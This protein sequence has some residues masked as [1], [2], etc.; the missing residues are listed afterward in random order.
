MGM[1]LTDT[2]CTFL[3]RLKDERAMGSGDD[4]LTDWEQEFIDDQIERYD[5][6][7]E[8]TRLSSRQ[9]EI[10]HKIAEKMGVDE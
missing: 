1:T 2:E 10:I 9:W 8:R 4:E 6:Y 5:T 7:G 3:E